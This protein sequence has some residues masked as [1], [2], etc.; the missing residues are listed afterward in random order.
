MRTKQKWNTDEVEC[1]F[2]TQHDGIH[3]IEYFEY[4]RR[5]DGAFL[6]RE[7]LS[8]QRKKSA[9]VRLPKAP[10]VKPKQ[11]TPRE[12]EIV[13]LIKEGFSTK[14]IAARIGTKEKTV[15]FHLT[16]IFKKF[17]CPNRTALLIRLLKSDSLELP[18][19]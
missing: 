17:G 8:M 4:R 13:P 6:H 16:G 19:L 11:L 14:E 9:K 10:V 18:S 2:Q 1:L 5:S 12:C 3:F 15:K 7:V